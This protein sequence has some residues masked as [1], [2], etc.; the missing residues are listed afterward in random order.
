ME[1]E[2][3]FIAGN[4]ERETEKAFFFE[5]TETLSKSGKTFKAWFPKSRSELAEVTNHHNQTRTGLITEDWL[6]A[7]KLEERANWIYENFGKSVQ[8]GIT[9][10]NEDCTKTAIMMA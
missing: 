7:K 10:W 5:F 3:L 1:N 4:I 8:V 6:V 2:K 9:V